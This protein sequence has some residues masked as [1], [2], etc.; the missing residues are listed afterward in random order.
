MVLSAGGCNICIYTSDL[1]IKLQRVLIMKENITG[2]QEIDLAKDKKIAEILESIP[3][4]CAAVLCLSS[5]FLVYSSSQHSLTVITSDIFLYIT[6]AQPTVCTFKDNN[7]L[8]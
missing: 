7:K 8:R 3:P 2:C 6:K 5:V 1:G 4:V